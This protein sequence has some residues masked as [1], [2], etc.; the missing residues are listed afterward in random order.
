MNGAAA[1]PPNTMMNPTISST[2]MI[3]VNHHFLLWRKIE[4]LPRQASGSLFRLLGEF[5]SIGLVFAGRLI[6]HL[7]MILLT[8]EG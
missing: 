4:E 2:T 7:R 1:L 3:G 5:V 6:A 8:R